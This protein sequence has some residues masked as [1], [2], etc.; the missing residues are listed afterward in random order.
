MKNKFSKIFK[1]F[2]AMTLFT[3]ISQIFFTKR[4]TKSLRLEVDIGNILNLDDC[5]M[6]S[7]K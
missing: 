2:F 3:E 7:R 6:Y 5:K 1:E 4:R